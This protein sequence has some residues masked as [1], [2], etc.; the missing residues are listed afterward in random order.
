MP[1]LL[2]PFV[3]QPL[4]FQTPPLLVF[5][6]LLACELSLPF[7][8]L[9]QPFL[10]DWPLHRSPESLPNHVSAFC[11]HQ[12]KEKGVSMFKLNNRHGFPANPHLD[13]MSR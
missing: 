1:P 7:S 8:F 5:L 4:L 12:V 9:L 3:S 11:G 10:F 6:P 13:Y 2:L